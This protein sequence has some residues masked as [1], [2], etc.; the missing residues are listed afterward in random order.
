MLTKNELS[1]SSSL[2]DEGEAK[3]R[4]RTRWLADG[5]EEEEE[6]ADE[7]LDVERDREILSSLQTAIQVLSS[8]DTLKRFSKSKD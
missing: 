4:S 5:Q 6:R 2:R 7:P 3:E 8:L 1:L